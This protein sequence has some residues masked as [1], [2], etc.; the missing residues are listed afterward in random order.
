M[1]PNKSHINYVYFKEEWIIDSGCTH[2]VTGDD[3]LFLELRQQ[4]G[5]RVIVTADKLTYPAMKEG[6]VEIGVNDTNI[7]LN[8]VYHVPRL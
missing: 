5:E 8:D 1:E 7:N 6:V 3:S 2:H 4:K